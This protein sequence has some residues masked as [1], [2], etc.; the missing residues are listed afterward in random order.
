MRV[1][2]AIDIDEKIRKSLGD[3]QAE[4]EGLA[5]DAGV[6]RGDVKWVNPK[7]MHLTL[8]FL[9]EIEDGKV[10]EV[11]DIV[12]DVSVKHKNFEINVE[13][14]GCFGGRSARVLWIGAGEGNDGLLALQK[15]LAQRFVAAGF[16]QEEREFSGHL[17]LCRIRNPKAGVKLSQISQ[18]YEGFKAGVVKADSVRVYKSELTPSGPI[19]TLLN[20][21]KLQ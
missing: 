11:C 21:Y 2:T 18:R 8:N 6:R 19:Y 9:G 13:K 15:E 7:A 17:T 5:N 16:P 1:F 4:L 3:L 12:K 10:S 14:V 20:E